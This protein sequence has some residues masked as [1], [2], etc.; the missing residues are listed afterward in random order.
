MLFKKWTK[1]FFPSFTTKPLRMNNMLKFVTGK[2]M[3]DGFHL[4]NCPIGWICAHC[5]LRILFLTERSR[6]NS[7]SP[8]SHPPEIWSFFFIFF[9]MKSI[10]RSDQNCSCLTNISWSFTELVDCLDIVKL[11]G[12][13]FSLVIIAASPDL[14]IV[15]T[16]NYYCS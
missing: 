14:G 1:N 16:L 7:A 6:A 4:S 5:S 9:L 8:Y 13:S 3:G 10:F 11:W 15:P 2:I 12:N